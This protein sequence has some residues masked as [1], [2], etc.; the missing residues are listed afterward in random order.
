MDLFKR[1]PD[2]PDDEGGGERP[3]VMR[4]LP[5]PI[6]ADHVV[7]IRGQPDA[8]TAPDEQ[9]TTI[10]APVPESLAQASSSDAHTVDDRVGAARPPD[11][12]PSSQDPDYLKYLKDLRELAEEHIRQ[13]KLREKIPQG[14][15]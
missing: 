2:V 11:I 3:E 14:S 9:E 10:A 15:R 8:H 13:H 12:A 5:P 4:P 1:E 6:P 7:I